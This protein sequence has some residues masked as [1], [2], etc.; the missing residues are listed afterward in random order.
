MHSQH[1]IIISRLNSFFS[2]ATVL[3]VYPVSIT[4]RTD[5]LQLQLLHHTNFCNLVN[6]AAHGWPRVHHVTLYPD[7]WTCASYRSTA[8]LAYNCLVHLC[9]PRQRSQP[10]RVQPWHNRKELQ[11][12]S[13]LPPPLLPRCTR[14]SSWGPCRKRTPRMRTKGRGTSS[15]MRRTTGPCR[16]PPAARTAPMRWVSIT[17][18]G[19]CKI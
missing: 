18:T 12:R 14:A 17:L 6:R 11:R 9:V 4:K 13:L 5:V 1:A 15:W 10:V 19:R 8:Y 7:I 2:L 16:R 3:M